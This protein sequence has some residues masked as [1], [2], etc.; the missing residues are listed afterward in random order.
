MQRGTNNTPSGKWLKRNFTAGEPS[1]LERTDIK[2]LNNMQL[3]YEN[4]YNEYLGEI[5]N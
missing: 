4:I 2:N 5:F 1:A 3:L